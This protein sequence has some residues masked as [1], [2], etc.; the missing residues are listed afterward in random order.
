MFLPLPTHK[1]L[2]AIMRVTAFV[3]SLLVVLILDEFRSKVACENE[4]MPLM[5]NPYSR[6]AVY[7]ASFG[8]I[9]RESV[10]CPHNNS[11]QHIPR[12]NIK[13]SKLKA[14]QSN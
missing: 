10:Q 4:S 12:S 7:S 14:F 13:Q 3:Y 9:E 1:P 8:Y 11:A 6:I 5:C 2:R